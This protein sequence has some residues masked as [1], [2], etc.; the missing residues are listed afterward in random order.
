[1]KQPK[2]QSPGTTQRA[3][4]NPKLDSEYDGPNKALTA[5]TPAP[6]TPLQWPPRSNAPGTFGRGT[7][8][9]ATHTALNAAAP[10]PQE[11]LV[12][13]APKPSRNPSVETRG[14]AGPTTL[15]LRRAKTVW[16]WPDECLRR[17]HLSP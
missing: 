9:E 6:I 17:Y 2:R 3:Q 7:L 5:K 12:A 11:P 4:R 15:P 16:F 14:F 10:A 1:M 13:S 8:S